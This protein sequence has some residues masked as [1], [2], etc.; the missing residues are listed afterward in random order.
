M[1]F[2]HN[3]EIHFIKYLQVE[4]ENYEEF[5]LAS[6]HLGDP[7]NAFLLFFPVVYCLHRPTGVKVLW[8]ACMS[9]WI[10][11]ILKWLLHGHRPYWWVQDPSSSHVNNITLQQYRLTCETGP[12]S[13][14]GHAM[15]TASV[16]F[17]IVLSLINHVKPRVLIQL[18]IWMLFTVFMLAVCISRLFIATH[19]PHQVFLGTLVGLC[20]TLVMRKVDLHHLSFHKCLII[21]VAMPTSC[22]ITFY[23][24][25]WMHL[26]PQ[27]S[28]TL[29]TRYCADREWIH[30]D[31]TLFN[32]A[33]RDA[34]SVL[35]YG[36]FLLIS[37][38]VSSAITPTNDRNTQ[39]DKEQCLARTFILKMPAMILSL[40]ICQ[41]L[42]YIKPFH[43]QAIVYYI[44]TYTKFCV[45]ITIVMVTNIILGDNSVKYVK[46]S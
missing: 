32:A 39:N 9:E 21:S 20:L 29:A 1:D 4:F 43:T 17:C 6:S 31:T 34:G 40:S 25:K 22:I 23:A 12:G 18:I 26:D 41:L 8:M 5:M 36:T 7:R 19:F 14:S 24:L 42:E 27:W 46:K 13:P 11:A 10:N 35:G 15:V 2:L 38:R 30:L 44:V 37:K 33:Y 28:I 3:S 45:L 16:V